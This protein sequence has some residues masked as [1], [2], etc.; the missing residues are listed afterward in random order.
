[1]FDRL[2]KKLMVTQHVIQLLIKGIKETEKRKLIQLKKV[3][4]FF[5][6]KNL[7][8]PPCIRPDNHQLTNF[9]EPLH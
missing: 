8:H 9:K 2:W 5:I 1:M 7:F 3:F 4:V 6:F